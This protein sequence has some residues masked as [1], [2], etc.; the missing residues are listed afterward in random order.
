MRKIEIRKEKN[1]Q[2]EKCGYE[3]E[4]YEG[5]VVLEDGTILDENCFFNLAIDRLN[6]KSKVYGRSED[7]DNDL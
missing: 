7:Y 2:C 5:Y 6:A 4:K 1:M 3:F